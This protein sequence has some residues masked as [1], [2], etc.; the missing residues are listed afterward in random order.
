MP[1]SRRTQAADCLGVAPSEVGWVR[2]VSEGVS[3]VLG[4]IDLAPGD[5]L[6]MSRHGYGA[7]R[8]ALEHW[9][10]RRGASVRDAVFPV[11]AAVPGL[12]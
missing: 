10:Q 12:G 11:G 1:T 7:V 9:A 6:V 5:E 8:M 3:A 4:S 2:N